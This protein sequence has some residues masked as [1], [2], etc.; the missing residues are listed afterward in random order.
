MSPGPSCFV[1]RVPAQDSSSIRSRGFSAAWRRSSGITIS[2]RS[3]R[4]HR[5]SFSSVFSF[6]KGHSLQRQ[7]FSGGSGRYS[8]SGASLRIWWMI[9]SSVAMMNVFPGAVVANWRIERV[10]PTW[11]AYLRIESGHSGCAATRASGCCAFSRSSSRSENCSCTMQVP[12]HS[13]IG[14]PVFFARNAPRCRSGA[15]R[16]SFSGGIERTIF[17]A[18]D[19]VTMMSESA[20]TAAEQLMYVSETAPGCS[21]RHARNA[22]GGQEFSSEQPAS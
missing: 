18:F 8:R 5:Y 3:S 19:E 2:G 20:L 9:P 14:R 22:S 4:R 10:D 13:V 6:M 12:G 7:P 15:K 1:S 21:S 17:S 16:I 11:S